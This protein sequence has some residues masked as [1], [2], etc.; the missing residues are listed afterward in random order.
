MIW[1]GYRW[2]NPSNSWGVWFESGGNRG[3]TDFSLFMNEQQSFPRSSYWL[4]LFCSS[5]STG[6]VCLK[7]M[8]PD[9]DFLVYGA[10]EWRSVK[11]NDYDRRNC[12]G[13]DFT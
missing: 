12:S 10:V 11:C 4:L 8:V 9:D 5:F 13:Q 6:N 7:G 1:Y 3:G 2:P